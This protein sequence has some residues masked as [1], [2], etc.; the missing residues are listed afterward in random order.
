[1]IKNIE[2]LEE[3]INTLNISDNKKN[4]IIGIFKRIH[5]DFT[6]VEFKTKMLQENA[7]TSKTLLNNI[8]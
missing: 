1:M 5:K 4:E 3:E 6:K 8:K 7:T 2:I